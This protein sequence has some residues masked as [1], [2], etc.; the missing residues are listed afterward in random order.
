MHRVVCL[1][2]VLICI[3]SQPANAQTNKPFR[4][5]V[6]SGANVTSTGS[7]ELLEN[8]AADLN[9]LLPRPV[10]LL[11]AGNL[12]QEGHPSAFV[13]FQQ[14]MKTQN[15]PFYSAPGTRDV[16]WSLRGKET[17]SQTFG[18]LYQSFSYGGCHFV[19]LDTTIWRE[20]PGHLDMAQIKWLENDLKRLKKGTPIFL[21]LHHALGTDGTVVDNEEDLLRTIGPYNITAIFAGTGRTDLAWKVN[22][23]QCVRVPGLHEGGYLLVDV[24]PDDAI[25]RH[26]RVGESVTVMR[27]VVAIPLAARPFRR[28]AFLWDD[29]NLPLLE[30]RRPL[31]ELRVGNE[32]AHD[33][34]VQPSFRLNSGES[35]PMERDER[36]KESVSF[37]A[38]FSTRDLP[39]GFN[40]LQI[41]FVAPDGEVFQREEIFLVER[42]DRQPRRRWE[43]PF[44]SAEGIQSRPVLTEGTLY[45]TSLDGKIYAVDATNGKR[46]WTATTKASV[47]AT[48]VVANGLVYVGSTDHIFYALEARNGR[49]RWKFDAGAPVLRAAA[50]SGGTVCFLA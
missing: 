23:M 21:F 15:L 49:V 11:S 7:M 5:A 22:G 47:C 12:T 9:R 24:W 38:Q 28:V 50:I 10:L 14:W 37:M 13:R 27:E 19:L 44:T 30:R 8:F 1:I 33:D 41:R 3:A 29:P 16:Q 26:M 40:R 34:R 25:I 4:F 6:I 42:L 17:F 36:D 31:A 35:A 2:V 48:P 20:S 46:R 39:N 43:Q 45:V 18:K 32:G